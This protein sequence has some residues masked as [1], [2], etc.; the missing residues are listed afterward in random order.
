M[1]DAQIP[2][3]EI[4]PVA[5]TLMDFTKPMLIGEH[6]KEIPGPGPGGYD[7]NYVLFGMGADAKEKVDVH[8][9]AHPTYVIVD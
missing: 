9:M 8:G 1:N 6:V 3:G 5:D 7:H 4:I 2:L